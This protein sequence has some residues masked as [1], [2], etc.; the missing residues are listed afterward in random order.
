MLLPNKER[1]GG[2]GFRSEVRDGVDTVDAIEPV[3]REGVEEKGGELR[4][5]KGDAGLGF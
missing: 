1:G 5:V 2:L 3:A 4:G